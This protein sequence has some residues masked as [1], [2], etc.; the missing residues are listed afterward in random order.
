V[1]SEIEVLPFDVP[2]DASY[3]GIRAGLEAEGRPIGGR[4]C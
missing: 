3:G 1:L 4:I 2:A